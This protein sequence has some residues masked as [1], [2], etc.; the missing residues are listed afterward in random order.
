MSVCVCVC[1]CVCVSV[2]VSCRWV[3]GKYE[4]SVECRGGGGGFISRPVSCRQVLA[5]G[6]DVDVDQK[7][8]TERKPLSQAACSD[9]DC[10]IRY[11]K[12]R[13]G[14]VGKVHILHC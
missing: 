8:C 1:V 13:W 10:K 11:V 6:V 2:C 9:A 4:C 5:N 3:T 12:G 14:K 7:L